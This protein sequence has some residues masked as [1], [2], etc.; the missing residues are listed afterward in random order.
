[1]PGGCAAA[2]RLLAPARGAPRLLRPRPSSASRGEV[3][4]VSANCRVTDTPPRL[5]TLGTPWPVERWPPHPPGGWKPPHPKRRVVGGGLSIRRCREWQISP[6][7]VGTGRA[8][9]VGETAAQ[10]CSNAEG[11]RCG[12]RPPVAGGGVCRRS[13][14]RRT[15]LQPATAAP[16]KQKPHTVQREK[17]TGPPARPE[18][19]RHE[20]PDAS[21]GCG[22]GA[23]PLYSFDQVGTRPG[24]HGAPTFSIPPWSFT[25]ST[26]RSARSLA[27]TPVNSSPAIS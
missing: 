15:S 19:A 21:R 1:M 18:K 16:A 17:A 22:A 20:V 25:R 8:S 5:R 27:R 2:R 10:L 7:P 24:V 26:S 11:P 13:A 3:P 23:D 12:S 14:R 4:S 9:R 6:E